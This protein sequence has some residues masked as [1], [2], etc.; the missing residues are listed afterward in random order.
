MLKSISKDSKLHIVYTVL[1]VLFC[2]FRFQE[3]VFKTKFTAAMSPDGYCSVGGFQMLLDHVHESSKYVFNDQFRTEKIGSGI[4]EPGPF[5]LFWKMYFYTFSPFFDSFDINVYSVFI[6]ALLNGLFFYFLIFKFTRNAHLGF[7]GAILIACIYNYHIRINGHLLGLGSIFFP[8]LLVTCLIKLTQSLN[9][10]NVVLFSIASI[11]TFNMNEYYGFF[12]FWISFPILGYVVISDLI[13]GRIS[14]GKTAKLAAVAAFIHAGLMLMLYPTLIREKIINKLT[15]FDAS[16]I[17]GIAHPVETMMHYSV[18][19]LSEIF[20]IN[21]HFH[22]DSK[23]F[24]NFERTYYVGIFIFVFI[25]INLILTL[26][27]SQPNEKRIIISSFIIFITSLL[28]CLHPQYF[29]SLLKLNAKLAPMFRVTYRSLI[30]F[31]I[32]S[33]FLFLY[34]LFLVKKYVAFPKKAYLRSYL[35][36]AI[37]LVLIDLPYPNVLDKVAYQ[38]YPKSDTLA[39][40]K[41]DP[42]NYKVVEIPFYP[43][44]GSA[45]EKSYLYI[46]NY[47]YHRKSILNFPFAESNNHKFIA[48]VDSFA[49]SINEFTDN[50]LKIL[51]DLGVKIIIF[52]K[53]SKPPVDPKPFFANR[54]LELLQEDEDRAVFKI[55]NEMP[56]F[57]SKNL[58]FDYLLPKDKLF[59]FSSSCT[60]G[61]NKFFN[62]SH[63]AKVR[64]FNYLTQP[65]KANAT[66]EVRQ[67]GKSVTKQL[68]FELPPQEY[69]E[70]KVDDLIRD[71]LD[72]NADT[73]V[74]AELNQME[75][76]P[77]NVHN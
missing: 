39:F 30:Y 34:S 1:L 15:K 26:K 55:K 3:A 58:V 12:G 13:K 47:Y 16:Y 73:Q 36:I 52:N 32:I 57:N 38:A 10:K 21:P 50:S 43:F 74:K 14:I 75:R 20:V 41:N 65:L 72:I 77:D 22:P 31:D 6:I 2:V 18:K 71:Q 48:N 60:E 69:F 68:S 66:V 56:G 5:S 40:L 35:A 59:D 49:K 46:Y 17:K 7:L 24:E 27:K 9:L 23:F 37:V 45:P 42:G 76:L 4:G 28:L 70:T 11:L 25:F 64:F 63:K 53:K 19:S 33:I 51:N 8:I 29:P 62:C 67:N 44:T 54:N 61:E